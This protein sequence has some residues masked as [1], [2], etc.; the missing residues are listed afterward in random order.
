MK[1]LCPD[2]HMPE[3]CHALFL[4]NVPAVLMERTGPGWRVEAL[5]PTAECPHVDY[6][7]ERGVVQRG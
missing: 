1:L 2:E 4:D 3:L 6:L 7:I 5:R